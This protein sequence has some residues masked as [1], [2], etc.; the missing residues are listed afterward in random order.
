MSEFDSIVAEYLTGHY[1]IDEEGAEQAVK[2]YSH[3]VEEGQRLGH[4]VYY[5]ANKIADELDLEEKDEKDQYEEDFEDG[6]DEDDS[7]LDSDL[8]EDED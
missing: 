6:D 2:T 1:D 4:K 3:I 5:I 7:D 8:Y